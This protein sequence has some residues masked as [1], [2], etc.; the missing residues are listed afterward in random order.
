MCVEGKDAAEG[1]QF[2]LKTYAESL[3]VIMILKGVKP[4]RKEG[5]GI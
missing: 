2:L 5:M 4:L 1:K 3:H